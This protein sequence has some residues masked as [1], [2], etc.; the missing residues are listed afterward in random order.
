[1]LLG[2]VNY[3]GGRSNQKSSLMRGVIVPPSK[4]I[5]TN[6]MRWFIIKGGYYICMYVCVCIYIYIYIYATLK[7]VYG[8]TIKNEN[9]KRQREI[10]KAIGPASRTLAHRDDAI[11]YVYIYIYVYVYMN[12]YVYIYIYIYIHPPCY[13]D[14]LLLS[15]AASCPSEPRLT[16]YCLTN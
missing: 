14:T 4:L 10:D 16:S 3:E 5:V 6:I 9:S 13:L 8:R 12:I 7:D 11:P 15:R 2:G 1:M